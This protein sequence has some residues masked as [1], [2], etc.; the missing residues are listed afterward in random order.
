MHNSSKRF[1]FIADTKSGYKTNSPPIN[2]ENDGFKYTMNEK[3]I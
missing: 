1:S 3:R 2:K